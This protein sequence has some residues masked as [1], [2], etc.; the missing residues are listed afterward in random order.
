MNVDEE[1]RKIERRDRKR[2][3]RSDDEASDGGEGDDGMVRAI[4][5]AEK[6][7][8]RR[9][10]ATTKYRRSRSNSNSSKSDSDDTFDR[11]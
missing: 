9:V 4:K 7:T 3:R 11:P 5:R 6:H 10:Q 1:I 2:R 8:R